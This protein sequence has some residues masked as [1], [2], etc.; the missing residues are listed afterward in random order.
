MIINAKPSF[1]DGLD[2]EIFK[3]NYLQKL[4]VKFLLNLIKNMLPL[5]K[6][7]EKS[8]NIIIQ[9]KLTFQNTKSQQMNLNYENIKYLIKNNKNNIFANT[10]KILNF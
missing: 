6:E 8:K 3:E 4:M 2:I 9:I 5:I 7:I 1:P 10:M